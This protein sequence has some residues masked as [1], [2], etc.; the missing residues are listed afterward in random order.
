MNCVGAHMWSGHL[1]ASLHLLGVSVRR[2][3]WSRQTFVSV[4]L[5]A[6]ASLAVVGWS[7][8]HERSSAEFI[9]QVFQAVYVTFLLPIFCLS[10]GTAG[11]ASDWEER[12]LVYLLMTPLPR[13]LIFLAKAVASLA[14]SA[15]W[16]LGS[17]AFFCWLAGEPGIESLR[18]LWPAIWWATCAYVALFLLFSV[19]FRR[20]TIVALA[21]ALF[22]ETLIGSMPGIAKRLAVSFYARCMIFEAAAELGSHPTGPNSPELFLPISAAAAQTVLIL[23]SVGLTL[24]GLVVFTNKEY[25]R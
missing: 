6:F 15:A 16:T 25:A 23:L 1:S 10:Y 8:R 19:L 20:A 2:L 18:L 11:I 24:A 14:V 13:P 12:T 5:L 7:L 4:L 9:D 3:L 21:Y 17:L 22:L